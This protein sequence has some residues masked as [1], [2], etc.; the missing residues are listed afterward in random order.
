[1]W[2]SFS[3]R[4]NWGLKDSVPSGFYFFYK[5]GGGEKIAGKFEV[6][7]DDWG[8]IDY[9]G[10]KRL[11]DSVKDPADTKTKFVMLPLYMRAMSPQSCPT[12]CNPM[13]TSIS[14]LS[15]W[16]ATLLL[17]IIPHLATSFC[18]HETVSLFWKCIYS[19]ILTTYATYHPKYSTNVNSIL[20]TTLWRHL[21]PCWVVD[22]PHF[23]C[24]LFLI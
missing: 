12:L 24:L 13:K 2:I 7:L 20:M 22:Q 6:S 16:S 9:R 1:M 14:L 5:V 19:A 17:L 11:L 23:Y 4:S 18:K 10:V 15:C 21:S 3:A 8:T